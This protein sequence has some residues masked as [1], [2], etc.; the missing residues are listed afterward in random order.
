MNDAPSRPR[1]IQGSRKWL[2]LCHDVALSSLL[3]AAV[4]VWR[5]RFEPKPLPSEMVWRAT[6]AF[7]VISA[8]VFPIFD[9]HRGLWRYTGLRDVMRIIRAVVFANLLLLPVLFLTDRLADFPRTGLALEAP[10]IILALSLSRLAV[11]GWRRGDLVGLFQSDDPDAPWAVIIADP[12]AADAYIS[13]INR[14]GEQRLRPVGVIT[15]SVHPVGGLI[16]GVEI[17]GD[18]SQ[19]NPVLATLK[20]S[21]T[22]VRAVIADLRP[23]RDLMQSVVKA[24]AEAGVKVERR[25]SA[26]APLSPIEAA[27]L[28]DRPPRHLDAERASAMIEGRR[29]LVTGAG[30]TI[31]SELARQITALGPASI[32]LV[33]AS[34]YNLYA[35]DMA[36][37]E[38]KGGSS[39]RAELADVRDRVR[40]AQLFDETRPEVVLHAAALKHVPLMETHPCEAVLTNI[41]GARIVSELAR[42]QASALVFISTDKAVNPTNVM[43]ATKRV[44]EQVVRAICAGSS[45][46]ASV[47]RFGNVLG[48][49]GSVAPLFER[50]IAEGGPV[51]VTHPDME[52]YFMTVREAA[53]LVL[54]AAALPTLSRDTGGVY[55]LDMGD[56][57]KI[58]DLARQMILLHGLKPDLDI[59]VKYTGLRPGEK[60]F[61]EIFYGAEEVR[62]TS[63]DGVLSAH[64]ESTDWVELGP[65]VSRLLEVAARHDDA[66]TLALLGELAPEFVRSA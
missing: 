35:I 8:I 5:Y 24:A 9:L 65:R 61:E 18:M 47:V 21:G 14:G 23:G 27:D 36:L 49:T 62:E 1:K 20:D 32:T 30:G 44:A 38:M 11:R 12:P 40:M 22:E 26:G 29:V 53:S 57:V 60:L 15:P 4:L 37:R 3:M 19:L 41:G 16:H 58:D 64:A 59:E 50:Q 66:S 46:R 25:R 34:E 42:N 56:A 33:D 63:A 55:V 10:V 7:G 31:G 45:T 39:W 43:G 17:L 48:S 54:Q 51:T 52:R 28:L 6:I 13:E 2:V